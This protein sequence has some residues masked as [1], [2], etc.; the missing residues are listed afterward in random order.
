MHTGFRL[1]IKSE[2]FL[3]SASWVVHRSGNHQVQEVDKPFSAVFRETVINPFRLSHLE[4]ILQPGCEGIL[5]SH[6]ATKRAVLL[7]MLVQRG[8]RMENI[9]ETVSLYILLPRV[10]QSLFI[11]R[12]MRNTQIHPVGRMQSC[13]RIV[14][15][16]MV[17][18]LTTGLERVNWLMTGS[19]GIFRI[20]VF[21]KC[22]ESL[23]WPSDRR[24]LKQ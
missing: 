10:Q 19:C 14:L 20:Q 5:N 3:Q 6:R 4:K 18:I 2:G 8:H 7:E 22:G 11:V 17:H 16:Q 24:I 1:I 23:A 12:T 21:R 9:S 13:T 15:K